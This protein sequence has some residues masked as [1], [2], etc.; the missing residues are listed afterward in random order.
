VVT[1]TAEIQKTERYGVFLAL[2]VDLQII[3]RDS[4]S[5][6]AVYS[7]LCRT[8]AVQKSVA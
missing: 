4:D 5:G 6:L 1:Y 8:G 3:I 2:C 7:V